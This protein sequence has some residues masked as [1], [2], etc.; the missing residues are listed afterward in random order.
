VPV[1]QS[2]VCYR[3]GKPGH[4][5]RNCPTNGDSRFDVPKAK[6]TTGIPR[7]FLGTTEGTASPP[8]R[9]SPSLPETD[10][11][12]KGKDKD[13]ANKKVPSELRCPTC[14]NLL[15][16]AV[17]IPC[18]GTSYCDDCIRNYLLENEQECP[19]CGQEN[20]SPDSLVINKQL[21]QAVN[22]FKNV[23][24]ASPYMA[25]L[26]KSTTAVANNTEAKSQPATKVVS[27]SVNDKA[28]PE[29]EPVDMKVVKEVNETDSK[30][31]E[32][33][34][35]P[36]QQ[37]VKPVTS[38][39]H[40]IRVHHRE[41]TAQQGVGLKQGGAPFDPRRRQGDFLPRYHT[42]THSHLKDDFQP[43]Y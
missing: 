4:F 40:P 3:C 9:S 23:R 10:S 39:P 16:D 41:A 21:R 2:Y 37:P 28:T 25:S 42:F 35:K 38:Q 8:S 11:K 30:M 33:S 24:P 43:H 36:A 18:C 22:T 31:K 13:T 14:N 1:P 26:P 27:D 34:P 19:S 5:I 7:T 15:A 32:S 20:V 29:S 6:R 12:T 17:L